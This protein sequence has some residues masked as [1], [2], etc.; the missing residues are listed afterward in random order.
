MVGPRLAK[1][2]L[3]TLSNLF[4]ECLPA[5]QKPKTQLML[6]LIKNS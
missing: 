3:K 5:F 1:I 4:P 2:S 6:L